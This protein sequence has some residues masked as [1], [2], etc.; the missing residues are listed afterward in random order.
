MGVGGDGALGTVCMWQMSS[1]PQESSSIRPLLRP[2]Q[3][4][5]SAGEIP[6]T[7]TEV[8]AVTK[9]TSHCH[10]CLRVCLG[11]ADQV[12]P[13]QS[14]GIS[15]HVNQQDDKHHLTGHL[16]VKQ[17]SSE[18]CVCVCVSFPETTV[19]TFGELFTSA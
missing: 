11:R 3:V 10:F 12:K 15:Q 16:C 6:P 13:F 2:A 9:V 8:W 17:L 5:S 18:G 1:F 19:K 4:Q 7:L 14:G